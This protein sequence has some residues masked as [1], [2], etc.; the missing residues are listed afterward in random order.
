MEIL[1]HFWIG[2]YHNKN[3]KLIKE[4]NIK[5][6]IH[7]S[8]NEDYKKNMNL[9]EIRIPID[10]S[11]DDCYEFIN[12]S[13]YQHLFDITE[14][15]HEKIL[16]NENILLMGYESKQDIDSIIIAYFI[17]YGKLNIHDSIVYLRTKKNNIFYPKCIFYFSLNKFYNEINKKY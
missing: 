16:N 10:Y 7:L 11:D 6:I 14:Y 2:Y 15:I 12:N 3:I 1:P 4:K 9:E 5:N 13:L 17:R 8:K